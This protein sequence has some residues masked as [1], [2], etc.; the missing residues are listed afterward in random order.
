MAYANLP[1]KF[2]IAVNK[3]CPTFRVWFHF[4]PSAKHRTQHRI[5]IFFQGLQRSFIYLSTDVQ[6]NRA[7]NVDIRV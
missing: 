5:W 7:A 2:T 6:L 1:E 3:I 4:M